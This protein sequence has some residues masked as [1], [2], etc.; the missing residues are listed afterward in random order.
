VPTCTNC[1]LGPDIRTSGAPETKNITF[2]SSN[3]CS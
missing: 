2:K 3:Q 1:S